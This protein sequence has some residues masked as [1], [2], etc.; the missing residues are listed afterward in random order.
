MHLSHTLKRLNRHEHTHT[1]ESPLN[2]TQLE[3]DCFRGP[4]F[5]V[6]GDLSFSFEYN[7]SV[8]AP[9]YL[10]STPSS[11]ELY[12]FPFPGFLCLDLC[13]FSLPLFIW[14]TAVSIV[15][16]IQQLDAAGLSRFLCHL[17][18]CWAW[19][20]RCAFSLPPSLCL[21]WSDVAKDSQQTSRERWREGGK[22]EGG[23]AEGRWSA[24]KGV[25]SL[26]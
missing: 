3:P 14:L 18:E 17:C 6:W 19:P 26:L 15:S 16:E 21:H 22:K 25:P 23:A 24:L 8:F 1:Q 11:F 7:P 9:L 5:S 10:S 12:N 2:H 13:H 4:L 20:Q